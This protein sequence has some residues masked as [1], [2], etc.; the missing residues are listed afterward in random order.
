MLAS[1]HGQQDVVQMLVD[2][3]GDLLLKD[4]VSLSV[5]ECSDDGFHF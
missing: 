4:D 3:G 2:E 1:A 5:L